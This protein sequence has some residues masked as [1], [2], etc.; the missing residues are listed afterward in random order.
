[1]TIACILK[2]KGRIVES[3]REHM[4]LRDVADIL[5]AKHIGALLVVDRDGGMVG[6]VSERDVVR[7]IARHGADA[8]EDAVSTVMTRDVVTARE[9]D[10]VIEAAQRMSDGRFRHLPVLRD[11]K[12]VGMISTGDAIKF[13]LEQM[14]REQAAL[15]DYIAT[16]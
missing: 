4:T 11:G 2:A 7:A 6:I 16:A 12:V 8:L 1:M 15:K 3:V 5:A 9:S 10:G 13:R 14:E